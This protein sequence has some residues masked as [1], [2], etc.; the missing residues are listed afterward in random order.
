MD[1]PAQIP[2]PPTAEQRPYRYERHG[3]TI[4]DPWHWLRDPKYPEV[5]DPDV[6]AYLHA[7]NDYFDGWKAQH[8]GLIDQLF[9][10]MKGRIKEDE[11]SVPVRDGEFLYW[12]AFKPGAQYRTW[13]RKPV[14]SKDEG[15]VRGGDDQTIFDEPVEAEGKEYFR[16]GALDVSPDGKLLATL[17]DYDGSERFELRIRDLATGKD[18]ETVTK[19]GIG[20]PV[21]TS[22]SA[23][24]IFT[25][26]ND[27]WRS[28]RARYHRL[29][30]PAEEAVTLYEETEELGFSVGV[31]K[32]HDRSLVL[33][34]TGDNPTSEVR[35]V[36]RGHPR[37]A[38]TLS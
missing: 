25:E 30:A 23:G 26:V 6:L 1:K 31:Y 11:S 15:P 18:V 36:S 12:W 19:V 38:V 4:E 21:W 3:V 29:G 33:L 37:A 7:E 10:E 9:E 2:S 32:S 27:Q 16:L 24:I 17:A 13:Y 20:Q 14:L 8:Q 28:Y 22:D 35:F 5:D 34:S